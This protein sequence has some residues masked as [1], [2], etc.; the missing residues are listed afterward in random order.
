M[1]DETL[2]GAVI[3]ICGPP[4]T[5]KTTLAIGVRDALTA[6]G[7]AVLWLD[8]DDLRGVLGPADYSRA[9]RE[10]FYVAIGH[11]ARRAVEGGVTVVISATADRAAYRESVRHEVPRFV[12]VEL[13]CDPE[14]LR[15]R[16]PKGLYRKLAAGEISGLPG[17]DVP[18]ESSGRAD[19]MLDTA[20]LSPEAALARLLAAL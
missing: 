20:S 14:E 11:L 17:A 16:D 1:S 7:L 8:S 9:G 2:R 10:H 13:R 18:F 5:G 6:R 3:W 19:L 15:R 12:E 4:A